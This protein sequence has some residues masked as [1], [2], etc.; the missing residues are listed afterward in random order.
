[1]IS[2][3][4]GL[5]LLLQALGASGAGAGVASS[6]RPGDLL[7]LGLDLVSLSAIGKTR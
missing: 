2:L 1:M 5:E 7:R 3:E 6:G 4:S